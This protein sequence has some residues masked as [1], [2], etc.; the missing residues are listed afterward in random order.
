MLL[1]SFI[2]LCLITPC[3]MFISEC[4][5]MKAYFKKVFINQLREINLEIAFILK[6][7]SFGKI[8]RQSSL[9]CSC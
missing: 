6:E 2:I 8:F 3:N 4:M 1:I 5:R 7:S 9:C